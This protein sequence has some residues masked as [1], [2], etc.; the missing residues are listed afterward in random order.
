MICIIDIHSGKRLLEYL[1][2]INLTLYKNI[3][4]KGRTSIERKRRL[5]CA[6]HY[7][8]R[9]ISQTVFMLSISIN[10]QKPVG[11]IVIIEHNYKLAI[12]IMLCL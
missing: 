4:L 5:V 1:Y 3:F 12:N 7:T 6:K 2:M 8:S 9:P 11:A 10:G